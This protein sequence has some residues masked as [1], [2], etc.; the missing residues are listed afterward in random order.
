MDAREILELTDPNEHTNIIYRLRIGQQVFILPP[1]TEVISDQPDAQGGTTGD[2]VTSISREGAIS[3][4]TGDVKLLARLGLRIDQGDN[5]EI[6]RQG[7][8][9]EHSLARWNSAGG[10]TFELPD[11]WESIS[12][13]TIRG[14]IEDPFLYKVS[15]DGTQL[16]FNDVIP[17]GWPVM[18]IGNVRQV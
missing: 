5:L 18:A 1:N 8:D 3:V 4:L 12:W 10:Q 17:E 16:I 2:N 13:V 7:V 15:R 14:V 9:H 11:V 6:M